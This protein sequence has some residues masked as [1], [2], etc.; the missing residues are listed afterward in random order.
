MVTLEW[1]DRLAIVSLDRSDKRNALRSADWDDLTSA[2][3]DAEG[4]G[5]RCLLLTGA[6]GHFSSGHDLSEVE[7]G[8]TDARGLIA[9]HVNPALVTLRDTTVPT[10]AAVEGVCM[11]G[12]L[13]IAA[14]CDI[15]LCSD[16]AR[17]G[18]PYARAGILADGGVHAFL[19]ETLGHQWAS[20]LIYTARSLTAEEAFARG[21]CNEVH[22]AGELQAAARA[23]AGML[24][25]GP[26]EAFRRSKRI[27]RS[28]ASGEEALEMEAEFQAEV[29]RTDDAA[30]GLA[31]F[32]EKRA[33]V[34]RGT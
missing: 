14:A 30:E 34:F 20:Y 2:V 28:M 29:F 4:Q 22:P 19:R 33:P 15:V 23:F 24:A 11:G 27:L 7:P 26:T 18:V 6:G 5:A 25:A 1:T 21:L 16:T 31:A 12:G 13:C 8:R 32:F 10:V 3:R 9:R 17:L